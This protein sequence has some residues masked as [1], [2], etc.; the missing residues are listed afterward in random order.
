MRRL[1][2]LG[3]SWR[4]RPSSAGW[5]C[6]KDATRTFF[7]LRTQASLNRKDPSHYSFEVP[8]GWADWGYIWPHAVPE[9]RRA[10][11]GGVCRDDHALLGETTAAD[12]AAC[13]LPLRS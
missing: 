4:Q 8:D 2:A 11:G 3:G 10:G 7:P 12:V 5:W 13:L 1:T 6:R 9:A